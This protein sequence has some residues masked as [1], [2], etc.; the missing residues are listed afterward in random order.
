MRTFQQNLLVAVTLGLCGLCV[1]QWYAQT[2]QR[3]HIRKLEAAVYDKSAT[4]QDFTNSVR[5]MDRQIA[6]MDARL[7]A[8]KAEAKNN[9]DLLLTRSRELSRLQITA[10]GLT[11][12]IAD[13]KAAVE[14]LQAKLKE[15]YSGIQKQ[16][17]AL[18]ELVAQREDLVKKFN[19]SVKDR[20]DI[21]AKYNQLAEQVE[22]LQGTKP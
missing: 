1:Y 10:A 16:N 6:Q 2:G 15:A 21:V 3:N 12:Q 18:K 8:I 13:Y 9:A 7:T 5:T 4:I 17:D 11:N 22:K 19:E 14:N 20:N